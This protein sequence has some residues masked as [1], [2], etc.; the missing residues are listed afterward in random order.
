MYA[1]NMLYDVTGKLQNPE[2]YKFLESSVESYNW[3][4]IYKSIN[5]YKIFIIYR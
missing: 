2:F 3:K 4:C 1:Y 5:T